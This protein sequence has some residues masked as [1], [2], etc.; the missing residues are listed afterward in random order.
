MVKS[1]DLS[2]EY[3][4]DVVVNINFHCIIFLLTISIDDQTDVHPPNL[5]RITEM[6]DEPDMA[7]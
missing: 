2:I 6:G 7:I 4:R 1:I 5:M 3:S